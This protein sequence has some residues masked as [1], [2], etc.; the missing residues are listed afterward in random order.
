MKKEI[1]ISRMY[2]GKYLKDNLGHEAI[3]LFKT[4]DGQSLDI[5]QK[6]Q[7]KI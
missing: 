5:M 3:I 2:T 6:F 7:S 1:V 4:D